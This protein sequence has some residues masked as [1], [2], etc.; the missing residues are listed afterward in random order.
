MKKILLIIAALGLL[1]SPFAQVAQAEYKEFTLMS[2][3]YTT[4]AVNNQYLPNYVTG[5]WYDTSEGMGRKIPA[6]KVSAY[7]SSGWG[8]YVWIGET[9]DKGNG[10][11]ADVT[12][13]IEDSPDKRYWRKIVDCNSIGQTASAVYSNNLGCP[14]QQMSANYSSVGRYVRARIVTV[15]EITGLGLEVKFFMRD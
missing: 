2:G 5:S 4:T 1:L 10:S 11:A 8:Y 15:R 9:V 14:A 3:R 12:L 7:S 6:G 13:V